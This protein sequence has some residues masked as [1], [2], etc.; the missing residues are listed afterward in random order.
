[1]S[2]RLERTEQAVQD[3]VAKIARQREALAA[4]EER[5]G[6]L[7]QAWEGL[8]LAHDLDGADNGKAITTNEGQQMEADRQASRTRVV[9]AELEK[10]LQDAEREL[11]E[12]G[13][14]ERLAQLEL[15]KARD[16]ELDS[17]F[18]ELA[19]EWVTLAE[20]VQANREQYDALYAEAIRSARQTGLQRPASNTEAP[21]LLYQ[22]A[23]GTALSLANVLR[24]IL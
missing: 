23:K 8:C 16:A 19:P 7:A 24:G 2:T 3:L 21:P 9:L 22:N 15:L 17:R 18:R 14:E 20:D 13:H 10:R 1:M 12:A 6:A 11:A 5:K 4:A